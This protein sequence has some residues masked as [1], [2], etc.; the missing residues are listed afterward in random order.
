MDDRAQGVRQT[1]R[2]SRQSIKMSL[3]STTSGQALWSKCLSHF[4]VATGLKR[5]RREADS[6][7]PS[8]VE[9]KY[10]WSYTFIDPYVFMMWNNFARALMYC[11]TPAPEL[12]QTARVQ[13]SLNNN[14]TAKYD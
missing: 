2:Y 3:F 8:S 11:L 13:P 9:A 7:P 14:C 5:Q 4:Q 12:S 6:S 10:A 1:N